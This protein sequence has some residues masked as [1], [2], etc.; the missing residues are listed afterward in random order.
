M[1]LQFAG[2]RGAEF[3]RNTQGK[4]TVK[5]T[6]GALNAGVLKAALRTVGDIHKFGEPQI[7]QVNHV[8]L[9]F[10]DQSSDH[11]HRSL[12]S[13]I[14][15]RMTS[16]RLSKGSMDI[17]SKAFVCR[18]PSPPQSPRLLRHRHVLLLLPIMQVVLMLIIQRMLGPSHTLPR[19][20][21]P[22]N[23]FLVNARSRRPCTRS[24]L[25]L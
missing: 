24:Q 11:C 10:R 6:D 19:I 1:P 4:I 17:F 18:S 13:N 12:R 22:N 23:R 3:V 20:R 2:G 14:S 16:R 9:D 5:I 15:M 8:L 21:S 25:R 7:G